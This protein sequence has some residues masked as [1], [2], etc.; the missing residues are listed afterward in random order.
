[1]TASD[2]I[3]QYGTPDAEYQAKYCTMWQ[4]KERFPWF[5]AEKIFINI[6]FMNKLVISFQA[7]QDANLQGEIITFNGCYVDR[8]V[9]GSNSISAH[10]YAAAID[11]DSAIDGMV[12]NP[13]TQQRLGKWTPE[14]ITAMLSSGIYYGGNFIHRADPMHF[15]LADM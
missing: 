2:L 14:F 8:P 5:P 10:A 15:S 12:V 4:V 13:T 9:R 7:V 6:V 1:M 11:M 3:A